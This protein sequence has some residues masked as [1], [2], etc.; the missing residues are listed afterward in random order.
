MI[1]NKT[2][3]TIFAWYDFW[4]G[5]FYNTKK[6]VLYVFP[7]PMV[8]LE[9]QVIPKGYSVKATKSCWNGVKPKPAYIAYKHFEFDEEP[10]Q[11]GTF[12]TW[13][14]AYKAVLQSKNLKV[15]SS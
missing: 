14:G 3:K 8:G 7:I 5:L 4:I 11:L 6:G 2:M 1:N 12:H 10:F 13:I 9:I 15:Y